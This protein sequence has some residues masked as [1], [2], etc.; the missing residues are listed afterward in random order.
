MVLRWTC[1]HHEL[2]RRIAREGPEVT[3]PHDAVLTHV[4]IAD[5]DIDR[6]QV[7]GDGYM[8]VDTSQTRAAIPWVEQEGEASHFVLESV[9]DIF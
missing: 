5:T 9:E 8:A 3:Q 1:T 6:F 7:V 2:K 4:L